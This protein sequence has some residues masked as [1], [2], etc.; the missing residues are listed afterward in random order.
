MFEMMTA[1]IS[2]HREVPGQTHPPVGRTLDLGYL[3]AAVCA[4]AVVPSLWLP[5]LTAAGP[6]GAVSSDAF[7]RLRGVTGV[8]SVWSGDASII[9]IGGTCAV[10]AAIAAVVTVFAALFY[11]RSRSAVSSYA[12]CA[13][14]V[15][16]AGCALCQVLY[17]NG[18]SADLRSLTDYRGTVLGNLG[19]LFGLLGGRRIGD[20]HALSSAG[21]GVGALLGGGAALGAALSAAATAIRK[22]GSDLSRAS[23]APTAAATEAVGATTGTATTVPQPPVGATASG[24]VEPAG[25]TSAAEPQ[26]PD[27]VWAEF[28]AGGKRGHAA[29]VGPWAGVQI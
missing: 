16:M 24:E 12:V 1:P 23:G 7:G 26:F 19:N 21:L 8:Q 29:A 2:A 17:L 18:K 13:A 22:H 25:P 20:G 3:C 10:L 15:A 5:W 28:V 11:F 6:N 14:A 9:E 4:L 27:E